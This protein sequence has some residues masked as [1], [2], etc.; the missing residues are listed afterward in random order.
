M[1]A[2]MAYTQTQGIL[3]QMTERMYR[4]Y[5]GHP[6]DWESQANWAWL[7]AWNNYD[8]SQGEFTTYLTHT[9]KG[10][11][12]ELLRNMR[13]QRRR[14]GDLTE[15]PVSPSKNNFSPMEFMET[16][17]RDA[18]ILATLALDAPADIRV[19]VFEKG[20][21]N[22]R[23]MRVALKEFLKELGWSLARIREAFWELGEALS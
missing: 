15:Q 18:K 4:Y 7:Q 9:V 11:M 13:K 22:R 14:A 20:G 16:L 17:S 3:N 6:S 10:A 8:P 5:G 2:E 21:F 19:T 23:N 12:L 1:N